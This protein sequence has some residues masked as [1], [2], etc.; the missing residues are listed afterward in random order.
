VWV[1]YP[2]KKYV[3]SDLYRH[4]TTRLPA[5]FLFPLTRTMSKLYGLH[6]L[7]LLG[8]LVQIVVPISEEADPEWRALDTFDW[9]APRYQWRH[10][11]SE[12]VAWFHELGFEDVDVL[13]WVTGVRGRRKVAAVEGPNGV[14]N[15]GTVDSE[16]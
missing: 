4:V 11:P 5:R 15:L 6:R 12:V 14:S 3:F 13:P 16:R 10:R 7:P 1:Y 9:Y 8:R 2:L